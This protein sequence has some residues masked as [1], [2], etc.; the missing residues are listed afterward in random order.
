[1]VKFSLK[2]KLTLLT[3]LIIVFLGILS[4]V[5]VFL[6]S[7]NI[8]ID[9][10]KDELQIITTE[11]SHEINQIFSQA[12]D[13]V[14]TIS[15]QEEIVSYLE[16]FEEYQRE[17]ILNILE[18]YNIGGK[19]SAIYLMTRE[20]L[21]IA[22]TNE[23]FVGNKYAFREYFKQSL[24]GIPWI[25]VSIGATSRQLGYYFSNPVRLGEEIVGVAI[26]K[27]IPDFIH[28]AIR[29]HSEGEYEENI[30]LVDEYGVV[31]FS[32]KEERIYKSIGKLEEED[33]RDIENKRRFIGV[34]IKPLLYN[35]IQND[36]KNIR[37]VKQFEFFD[38]ESDG[39]KILSTA[40]IGNS[41]F[42]IILEEEANKYIIQARYIAGI[43]SI[44][45]LV[46]AF[47]SVLIVY[48]LLVKFLKPLSK[49]KQAA[50]E[51]G[52]GKLEGSIDIKTGDEIEELARVF[53]K[54]VV[55][56]KES[57]VEI[58]KKVTDQTWELAIKRG[59]MENQQK[60]ILNV[61]EDVKREK[62]KS[63]RLA[64]Q[65]KNLAEKMKIA[66]QSANI[67]VWDWDIV[68][69]VLKWD[70][71]MYKIYGIEESDFSE[72]Y[73]SWQKSLH[74]D[75]LERANEEVEM[76]LEDKKDFDTDFRIVWPDGSVRY[77]KAYAK[78]QR[79][80]EGK[81]VKMIGVNWD[82]TQSKEIDKVK[83]EFVSLASHQLRTPLSTI[84][85]YV[86]ILLDE[87]MGDLNKKQ[88]EYLDEIYKGNLRMVELVSALL[89]VSR[90]ELGTFSVEPELVRI[91][92]ISNTVIKELRPKIK[93][94]KI[95]F[96]KDY[97]ES[98][99]RMSLDRRLMG[100]IFQN[101]L[102]NSIK[103]TL[104]G[105][106]V[107][108]KIS[109]EKEV[110]RIVVSDTGLGIPKSQHK[111]IFKKLF[112]ADNVKVT[113]TEGTGLGLYIVKSVLDQSGGKIWFE[114]KENKGT[115]FFVEIPLEGMKSK[116][117][118][119]TLNL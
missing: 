62:L 72:A 103:Y 93:E 34:E 83:T 74:P 108:L 78:V 46:S 5:S 100:M 91:T 4:T 114:S 27:M 52:A 99:G 60:A 57:R 104:E 84:R 53:N 54:M 82:I 68:N 65:I 17:D 111:N 28:E 69:N 50:E 2:K 61:L 79:D 18:S 23:S 85:W 7:R 101:L 75:D 95:K 21:V 29:S 37:V 63:D 107:S 24:R 8:F 88:K 98:L 47:L 112:R 30:M 16:N 22:S 15:K 3:V 109:K 76:A 45:V 12:K 38:E 39:L 81:A 118:T 94:K 92:T 41:P 106:E 25:D 96:S 42:Y 19:Y 51:V 49:L 13:L 40:K 67:G 36:L 35:E 110:V 116:K 102:S 9:N 56:I 43:I 119:K 113:D 87:D 55:D 77:I 117:G 80:E 14:K 48:F 90:L 71:N 97:D 66:T 6:Y 11:Q 64:K 115:T 44:F 1:M 58:D 26:V 89:N 105:G 32:N 59:E 20:A 86:E 70:E 33:L 73:E 10:K 31:V